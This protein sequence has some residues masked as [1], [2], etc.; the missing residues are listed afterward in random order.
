MCVGAL[1]P[2]LQRLRTGLGRA[3]N[4]CTRPGL[5]DV[6]TV[7]CNCQH[8]RQWIQ[9]DSIAERLQRRSEGGR[10]ARCRQREE[11]LAASMIVLIVQNV[12]FPIVAVLILL[13]NAASALSTL[14]QCLR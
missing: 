14:L 5:M 2:K 8:Q 6:E 7:H 3:T 9:L 1:V 11:L 4:V 12:P 10:S 13:L